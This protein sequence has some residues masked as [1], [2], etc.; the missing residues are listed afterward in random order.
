MNKDYLSQKIK[1]LKD[2]KKV[3]DVSIL[4]EFENKNLTRF[5]EN[6]IIQNVSKETNDIYITALNDK[7][8]GTAGTQDISDESLLR[9]LRRAEEIALSSPRDPEFVEPLEPME[10]EE[11][12]QYFKKTKELTPKEKAE[13]INEIKREAVKRKITIAG[14]YLNGE[15]FVGF[16]NSR[17]HLVTH[18]STLA[19]LS[20]TAMLEDS[21]GYAG[22]ADENIDNIKPGSIADIAFRKAELGRNPSEIKPG[23]YPVIL[24]PQAV[25]DLLPYIAWTMDRRA[26][27]EGYVYFS[28]RLGE[29]IVD[30]TINLYSDPFHPDNPSQPFVSGN[31]LPLKKTYWINNGILKNLHTSRYWAKEKSLE[32]IGFPTN[33]ILDGG[34]KSL[35]QLIGKCVD[36]L[37][38]TRLWYIRYVNR[39]DLILTGMT[40]DGVYQIKDGKVVKAIKNMRFNDNP[41]RLLD[42]LIELGKVQ[43]VEEY[44]ILPPVWSRGFK[45][46]SGT[47]F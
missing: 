21:S 26:A 43:R 45:L 30:S 7:S 16:A 39:Q 36:A 24:E 3:Q 31:G 46:S 12:D 33:V 20:L 27:D 17:G 42:S 5:A 14:R 15:Y 13:E 9:N 18:R 47:L 19:E 29:K 35:S 28:G 38:I 10:I 4:V 1:F 23:E 8:T 32:P 37:L 25:A 2:N 6:R 22:K 11:V 40:R 34:N 41:L 44:A